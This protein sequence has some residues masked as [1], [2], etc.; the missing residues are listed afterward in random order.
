MFEIDEVKERTID[1]TGAKLT[2][3]HQAKLARIGG[4][5]TS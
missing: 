1:Q 4:R 5:H 3:V 2:Y